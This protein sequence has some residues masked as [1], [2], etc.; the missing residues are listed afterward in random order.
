MPKPQYLQI[1]DDFNSAIDE[2]F[3]DEVRIMAGW[4]RQVASGM[5][6]EMEK[7]AAELAERKATGRPYHDEAL[8]QLGRY[9]ELLAQINDRIGELNEQTIPLLERE[10][11]IWAAYGEVFGQD[12]VNSLTKQLPLSGPG[13]IALSMDHLRSEA[14]QNIVG[15]AR[16]GQPLGNL[17]AR[18]SPE[19]A[20]TM[21]EVLV[22][23]TAMG[24]WPRETAKLMMEKGFGAGLNRA[25]LIARD[26][27]IRAYREASR[28]TYASMGVK[29]YMRL[30][31]HNY[32]TCLSRET[33]VRVKGAFKPIEE[34]RP[35]DLVVTRYGL[36]RVLLM[37]RRWYEGRIITIEYSGGN[38][39]CTPDHLIW[40]DTK[41]G[42]VRADEVRPGWRLR[43]YRDAG[44]VV[45]VDSWIDRIEVFNLTIENI[46]EFYANGVLVHNCA[47]C[48]AM[49]GS[50]WPIDQLMPLHPQDRCTMIPVLRPELMPEI[51]EN[52]A[53]WFAK[54]SAG[55]QEKI[56]GP[57]RLQA[58][59]EG[60]FQFGQLVTVSN[61]PIWGPTAHVTSLKNLLDGR[62]GLP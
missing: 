23:S 44:E 17:L 31:A 34:V 7:L 48:L 47:A 16:Q 13:S 11:A 3:A 12:M 5:L 60:R 61:H 39:I 27:Q 2:R 24:R 26:Q 45:K 6:A 55:V 32:R 9:H 15:L 62:G 42:W 30:A 37:S 14:I 8:Y 49:D 58:W 20:I 59:K 10:Q 1:I 46:P 25:L 28:Q 29:Q 57:D 35:G 43:M 54:Q 51:K 40:S 19:T 33:L 36:D 56:L 50:I 18:I 41:H 22:S 21:S 38:I 52:G 53:E 4:Y